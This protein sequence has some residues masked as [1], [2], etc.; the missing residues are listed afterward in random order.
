MA[1]PEGRKPQARRTEERGSKGQEGWSSVGG[2]FSS[3]QRGSLGSAVSSS[4]GF[5]A[6]PR[7]PGDWE[8]F[9]GLQNSY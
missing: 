6:K 7:G 3:H 1:K 5:G 8:R 9:I 2:M 4:M